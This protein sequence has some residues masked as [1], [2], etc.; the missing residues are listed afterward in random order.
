MRPR[1]WQPPAE[2]SP[3][4]QGVITAIKRAKLFIFL[5]LHRHEVFD[6]AFQDELAGMYGDAAKGQPPVPPA[7]LCACR[8]PRPCSS[9]GV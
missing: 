7:Q 2:L 6:A 3:A 5:R 8:N 9:S 4:E 1:P